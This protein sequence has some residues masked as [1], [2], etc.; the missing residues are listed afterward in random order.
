MLISWSS[1]IDEGGD[2]VI[3]LCD[4]V[5]LCFVVCIELLCGYGIDM[6][7]WEM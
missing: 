6:G 7:K 1:K 4:R 2:V 3:V 5:I